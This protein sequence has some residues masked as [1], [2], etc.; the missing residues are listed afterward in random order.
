MPKTEFVKCRKNNEATKIFNRLS[1][2]ADLKA[3]MVAFCCDICGCEIRTL[4]YY[5]LCAKCHEK[6]KQGTAK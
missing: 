2:Q 6:N 4:D 1:R 5:P 3:N